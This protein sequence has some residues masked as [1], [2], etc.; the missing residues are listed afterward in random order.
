MKITDDAATEFLLD[1]VVE[2][3]PVGEVRR[4]VGRGEPVR[5]LLLPAD[6][7]LLAEAEIYTPKE[8]EIWHNVE[9]IKRYNQWC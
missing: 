8:H 4:C 6:G 1:P 2:F 7:L 5:F 3:T 9:T